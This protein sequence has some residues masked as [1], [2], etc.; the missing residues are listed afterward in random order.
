MDSEQL[1]SASATVIVA[2]STSSRFFYW[3]EF[4]LRHVVI[5]R[6]RAY[7]LKLHRGVDYADSSM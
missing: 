6:T 1:N 4:R 7:S 5:E 2:G 3:L